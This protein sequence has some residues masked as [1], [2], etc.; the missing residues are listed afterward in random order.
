MFTF[1]DIVRIDN[2][3]MQRLLRDVDRKDLALALKVASDELKEA[4]FA[5]MTQRA[6]AR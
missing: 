3:S 4:I 2:R 1:E 6:L 5:G